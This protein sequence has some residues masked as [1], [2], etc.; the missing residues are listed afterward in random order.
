M[1]KIKNEGIHTKMTA[2]PA[3]R[4]GEKQPNIGPGKLIPA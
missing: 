2:A 1:I 4:L 3:L